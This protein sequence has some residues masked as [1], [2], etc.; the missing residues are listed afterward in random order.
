MCILLYTYMYSILNTEL[1]S[2]GSSVGDNRLPTQH[3]MY[4]EVPLTKGV[5]FFDK[6]Y[7]KALTQEYL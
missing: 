2:Y 6:L 1:Y 5:P 7:N 4:Q 3:D